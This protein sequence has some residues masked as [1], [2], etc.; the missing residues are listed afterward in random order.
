[1]RSSFVTVTRNLYPRILLHKTCTHNSTK[2]VSVTSCSQTLSTTDEMSERSTNRM[3]LLLWE[4]E[5][6][7]DVK[8]RRD[9]NYYVNGKTVAPTGLHLRMLVSRIRY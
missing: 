6:N 3:R 4:T 9:G 8:R 1:M 5:S 2:K 7:D